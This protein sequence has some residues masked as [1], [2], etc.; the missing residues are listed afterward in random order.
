MLLVFELLVVLGDFLF[1]SFLLLGFL[2]DVVNLKWFPFWGM[3]LCDITT[4]SF[5]V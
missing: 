2:L 5:F 3:G 4:T 1:F